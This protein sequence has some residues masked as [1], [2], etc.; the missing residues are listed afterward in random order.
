MM[1]NSYDVLNAFSSQ[2]CKLMCAATDLT[3]K[4]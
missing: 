4:Q 1:M 3:G 2:N